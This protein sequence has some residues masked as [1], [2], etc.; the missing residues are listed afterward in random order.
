MNIQLSKT[1]IGLDGIPAAETVL[2]HVNGE[3]GELI[4]A[5]EHVAD[6]AAPSNID[7]VTAR[8]WNGA[9]GRTVNETEVQMSLC[10]A[11]QRAFARLPELLAASCGLS[12]IDGFRVG[13]AALRAEDG[14]DH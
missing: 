8:L 7:A 5:G 1:P 11:R 13:M 9:T 2:S 10:M 12:I 6:L 14:L 4:I 3:Q